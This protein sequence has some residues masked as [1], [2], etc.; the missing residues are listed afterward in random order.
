[1]KEIFIFP[2]FSKHLFEGLKQVNTTALFR[3]IKNKMTHLSHTLFSPLHPC[4]PAERITLGF[5]SAVKQY[6]CLICRGKLS[7]LKLKKYLFP[8]VFASDI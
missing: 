4:S 3:N 7:W 2:S 5:V 1:M 8:N 6:K